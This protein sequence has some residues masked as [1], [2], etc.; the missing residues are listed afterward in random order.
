MARKAFR[1]LSLHYPRGQS[2]Q[3]EI[4]GLRGLGFRGSGTVYG[5]VYDYWVLGPLGFEPH[6]KVRGI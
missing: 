3:H 5:Q 4:I 6:L 1:F 2:I